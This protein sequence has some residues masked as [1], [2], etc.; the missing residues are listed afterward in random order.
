MLEKIT[1]RAKIKERLKNVQKAPTSSSLA[2][3]VNDNVRLNKEKVIFVKRKP[4][5]SSYIVFFT[6]F[7]ISE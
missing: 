2:L 7:F 3:K 4:V 6:L 1:L 5:T